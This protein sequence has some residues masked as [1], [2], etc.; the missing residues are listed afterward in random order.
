MLLALAVAAPGQ[1]LEPVLSYLGGLISLRVLGWL[2]L[3]SIPCMT[4]N[5]LTTSP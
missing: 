2:G 1:L 5:S 3:A 4:S